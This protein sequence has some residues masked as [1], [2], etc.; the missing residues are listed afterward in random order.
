MFLQNAV[1]VSTAQI[2]RNWRD[3]ESGAGQGRHSTT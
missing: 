3:E 2:T 1:A